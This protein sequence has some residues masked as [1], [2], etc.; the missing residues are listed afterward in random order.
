MKGW[1]SILMLSERGPQE[2][3]GVCDVRPRHLW[4]SHMAE[5][6]GDIMRRSK[7]AIRERHGREEERPGNYT[8]GTILSSDTRVP[9]STLP[10]SNDSLYVLLRHSANVASSPALHTLQA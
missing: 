7:I 2:E 6:N 1:V 10:L 8:V 3:L 4:C 9:V 5:K